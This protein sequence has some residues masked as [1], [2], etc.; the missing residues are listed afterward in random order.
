M[1]RPFA[2]MRQRPRLRALLLPALRLALSLG[3]LAIVLLWLDPAALA[4]AFAAPQPGWLLLAL[5]LSLPQIVLSAWRWR[6]T[7]HQ[8][9]V[10]LRLRHAVAEYYL[11][12]FLNQ[13]LPG[14]VMGDAGRAWRH[15]RSTDAAAGQRAGAWHAVLVERASGQLALLIVALLALAWSPALQAVP[16]HMLGLGNAAHGGSAAALAW[17]LLAGVVLVGLALWRR[18]AVLVHLGRAAR[19]AL[20]ARA[21]FARQLIASL[22]IVASYLAVYLCCMRMVGI[23]TPFGEVLPLVPWVLLA[24]AIPLSI[25]GWGIR[26]GAAA[27]VW[28]LAGLNAAEGVAIS[29][30]YGLVVLLSSLPGALL[31]LPR[32]R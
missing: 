31:L 7:A 22:L 20:L 26:E 6:L 11:A 24:M 16:A 9:G 4:Q 19:R 13:M 29:V 1:A 28:S 8:L 21:V 3:L 27:L 30:S 23:T 15:A 5:G 17:L 18:P 14:G 2:L 32:R 25:A 12:T 10:P